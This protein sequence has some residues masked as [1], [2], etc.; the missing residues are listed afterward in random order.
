MKLHEKKQSV[1]LTWGMFWWEDKGS[2]CGRV[3]RQRCCLTN[4]NYLFSP[5]FVPLI[6]VNLDFFFPFLNLSTS[7]R[8]SQKVKFP[9]KNTVNTIYEDVKLLKESIGVVHQ[10]ELLVFNSS[11]LTILF[12]LLQTDLPLS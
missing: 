11:C 10:H 1:K 5:T 2:V 6:A 12:P 8:T 4:G 7:E 3:E 9:N